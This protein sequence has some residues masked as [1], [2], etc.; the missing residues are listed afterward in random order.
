MEIM[1][2]SM[3]KQIKITV[4]CYDP[5]SIWAGLL[6]PHCKL[7]AI[8]PII[9]A[10]Q[11]HRR[12][13]LSMLRRVWWQCGCL[14]WELKSRRSQRGRAMQRAELAHNEFSG[15]PRVKFCSIGLKWFNLYSSIISSHILCNR[16]F[17][18]LC[19]LSSIAPTHN[20]YSI[21]LYYLCFSVEKEPFQN[22]RL[23]ETA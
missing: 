7:D 19:L 23:W 2:E 10:Q 21:T 12:Q 14:M 8:P 15:E 5:P 3:E 11:Q 18:N 22:K 13:L 16:F 1:A 17:K 20:I 6:F 9:Q 4:W